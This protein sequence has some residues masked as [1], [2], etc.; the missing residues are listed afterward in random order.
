[1]TPD[2][3]QPTLDDIAW[4]VGPDGDA[5]LRELATAGHSAASDKLL[6]KFARPLGN[7][8]GSLLS[9]T[10]NLRQRARRKFDAAERMFFT[11]TALEQATDSTLARYK[12]ERFPRGKPLADLC[13]GIGGDLLALADVGEASGVDLD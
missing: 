4:L 13:C 11:T 3:S 7:V 1:M 12:A 10:W 8:R 9:M 5:C 2:D 6:F